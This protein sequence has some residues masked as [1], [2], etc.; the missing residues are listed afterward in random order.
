MTGGEDGM[1]LQNGQ[2]EESTRLGVR[3]VRSVE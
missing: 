3:W 1:G 2:K